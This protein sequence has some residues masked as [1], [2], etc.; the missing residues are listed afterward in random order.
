MRYNPHPPY[1]ILQN[2]L[3]DFATMQRLRRFAKYWDLVGNSGNFVETTP[4]VWSSVGQASS[5]SPA[6]RGNQQTDVLPG[7]DPAVSAGTGWKPVLRSPFTAFLCWSDWLYARVGRTDSIALSRLAELLFK[8]LVEEQGR[9]AQVV[10]E[11][12]WRD[13]QRGGRTDRPEFLRGWIG[14]EAQSAATRRR[15]SGLKRQA[16]HLGRP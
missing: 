5:L 8:F 15:V 10:A 6:F 13:Y 16:R 1:E 9:D 11:T 4:M 14:D 2:R 7:A 12:L 3:I